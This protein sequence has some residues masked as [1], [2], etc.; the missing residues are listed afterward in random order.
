MPRQ[1]AAW[2]A[3]LAVVWQAAFASGAH[4]AR[5]A[6]AVPPEMRVV[7]SMQSGPGASMTDVGGGAPADPAAGGSLLHCVLCG[8]AGGVDPVL[9]QRPSDL[10]APSAL[11]FAAPA[12]TTAPRADLSATG[13]PR[14]R[15]PPAF[16]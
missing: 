16:C 6:S 11:R 5:D 12:L 10:P 2:I 15:G 14:L 3:C 8:G 7:C 9:V 1:W 13:P 4:A